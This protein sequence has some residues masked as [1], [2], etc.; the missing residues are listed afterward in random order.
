[1][2]VLLAGLVLFFSA[3]FFTLFRT[4]RAQLIARVGALP[5]RGL[6][7]VVSLAGFALIVLGFG[8]APNIDVWQPPAWLRHVTMLLMLP[9]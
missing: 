3:H 7:S 2:T 4:P 5:Y 6:F 1:M 8:H 9:V